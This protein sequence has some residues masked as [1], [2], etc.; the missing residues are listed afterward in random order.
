M[1]KEFLRPILLEVCTECLRRSL[2][3]GMP[4]DGP[5][6]KIPAQ[7]FT[8]RQVDPSIYD[9]VYSIWCKFYRVKFLGLDVSRK[10]SLSPHVIDAIWTIVVSLQYIEE[11]TRMK[12]IYKL[13][14]HKH[15]PKFI[16]TN[17][18]WLEF[19]TT[20]V[21]PKERKNGVGWGSDGGFRNLAYKFLV[22]W[23]NDKHKANHNLEI[24]TQ[25][26]QPPESRSIHLHF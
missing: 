5:C 20:L 12:P 18:Q 24:K 15:Q 11:D 4:G 16:M 14:R 10:I 23:R 7:L 6:E 19:P 9:Q 2:P 25:T 22:V 26:R 17:R 13:F 21:G 8:W 1:S 3:L